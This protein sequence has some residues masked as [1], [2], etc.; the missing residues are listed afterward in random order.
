M[1]GGGLVEVVGPGGVGLAQKT[2]DPQPG[3][4]VGGW[5]SP[6]THT[7][8]APGGPAAASRDPLPR[9]G[10][11][12]ERGKPSPHP[13]NSPLIYFFCQELL[14]GG[15]GWVPHLR[16]RVGH[17]GHSGGLAGRGVV[18]KDNRA[19]RP[20]MGRPRGG[21]CSR[22]LRPPGVCIIPGGGGGEHAPELEAGV[23]HLHDCGRAGGGDGFALGICKEA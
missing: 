10:C 4:P 23:A 8:R 12:V 14:R 9:T 1:G 15:G 20:A 2:N 16:G 3:P 19:T 13:I 22:A 6:H 11:D 18:V 5:G 7:A 21:G 17:S